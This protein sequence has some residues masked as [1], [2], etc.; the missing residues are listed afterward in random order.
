MTIALAQFLTIKK[1]DGTVLYRWQNYWPNQTVDNHS[2]APFQTDALFSAASPEVTSL[3]IVFPISSLILSLLDEGLNQYYVAQ[4][5][6]YQ[7]QPPKNGLPS[8]KTLIAGFTGE[9]VSAQVSSVSVDL[10]IGSNIDSTESQV[11]PRKF[12]TTLAGTPPKL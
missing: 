12:T 4:I 11:P 8:V 3:Q 10:V 6:Q 1:A 5:N 9:F 7:F 2:F